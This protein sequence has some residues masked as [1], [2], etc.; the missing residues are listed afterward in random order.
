MEQMAVLSELKKFSTAEKIFILEELWDSISAE[1]ESF[2]LTGE[3]M[4]ELDRRVADYYSSP[5]DGCSWEDVK[6]RIRSMK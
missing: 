6:N 2:G 5:D 3:Q 1:Q 4:D